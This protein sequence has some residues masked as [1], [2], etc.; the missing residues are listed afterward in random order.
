MGKICIDIVL[1][2]LVT[3]YIVDVSGFTE[4]WRGWL[5]G[6]LGVKRLR[7]LPPFDCGKC[8]TWWAC[9]I[10]AAVSGRFCLETVALSALM[11]LLSFPA[12]LL[13][14]FIREGLTAAADRLFEVCG[15]R[16]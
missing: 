13:M 9:V 1:V 6:V 5:A 14:I 12:G 11:S 16:R 2:A 3:V 10:Y 4:S 8:A 7:P 15:R